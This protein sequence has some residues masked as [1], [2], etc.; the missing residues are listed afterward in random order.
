MTSR[1]ARVVVEPSETAKPGPVVVPAGR[2]KPNAETETAGLAEPGGAIE[3]AG[4][5]KPGP[6]VVLLYVLLR[7]VWNLPR[8]IIIL[9][10]KGYRRIISPLYG[11]VCRFFPSCS[12]YALEAVTVHGAVKGS[13]L[14][15]RRLIRCHPW[16]AGGIDHVPDAHHH[17]GDPAKV[18]NIIRL[19]HPEK[20]LAQAT[21]G[22]GR[23]AA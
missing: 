23:A 13:W 19:N 12:A 16:N 8:N 11:Q 5:A 6:A 3:T 9:A 7:A 15:L 18:P 22:Q 1:A 21:E 2:A 14:A 20:F 17:H 4:P 10:L